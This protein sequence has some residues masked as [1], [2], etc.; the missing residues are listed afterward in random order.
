MIKTTTQLKGII[1]AV[2][3]PL[4]ENGNVDFT[5]LEKQVA[6]LSAAGVHGFFVNGSTGEGPYL[7]AQ[8][9]IDV[10]KLVKEVSN[11]RQF[12]CAAC[13]QPSTS[14]VLEE[15]RRIEALE[16]DFIVTITPYY[17]SVSQEVIKTHYRQIAQSTDIPVIIYDIPQCT[18]NKIALDTIL[19][20]A[21]SQEFAGIKD[22]SGDFITFTRAI[23]S[24]T[25][26]NF[27]WIQ[28]EDLLDGPSLSVGA[29]GLVTGLGNVWI[30]PYMELYQ[31]K[32]QGALEKF[33][34]FQKKINALYK[35]IQVTGGK[36]IPAIK[37]GAALLGRS[38]KWMK[39][40][41]LSLNEN[42]ILHVKEVLMELELL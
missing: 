20:L 29:D 40:T 15:I 41:T 21:S 32:E 6:Y 37:A 18:Y 24:D 9:K 35:V 1:P 14:L 19:E 11:G 39:M 7:T 36:V 31:A 26:P 42:E 27:S 10:F 4:A 2:I 5:S 33:N 25:P 28:G 34:D 16:P 12:L 22:S 23:Y 17:F 3:T 13:L 38:Q 8:E 30:D